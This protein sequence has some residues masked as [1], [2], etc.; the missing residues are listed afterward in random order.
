MKKIV[1]YT[2]LFGAIVIVISGG[3]YAE[4]VHGI[5]WWFAA[6]PLFAVVWPLLDLFY[7]KRRA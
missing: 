4:K 1:D 5:N 7:R 6:I 3:E 2:V